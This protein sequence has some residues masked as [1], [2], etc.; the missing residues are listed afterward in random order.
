MAKD[1][2]KDK[3][4]GKTA[5]ND[6]DEIIPNQPDAGNVSDDGPQT[7]AHMLR[8]LSMFLYL[9]F[10][11]CVLP[12][13]YSPDPMAQVMGGNKSMMLLV[14]TSIA[15]IF[16]LI[17]AYAKR[18]HAEGT[19]YHSHFH[20]MIRTFWIGGAVYMPVMT[21]VFVIVAYAQLPVNEI[22]AQIYDPTLDTSDPEAMRALSK[23]LTTTYGPTINRISMIC[24]AP[25]AG[26]W[27]LRQLRGL[28]LAVRKQEVTR[29]K[30]WLL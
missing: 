19:I 7:R 13:F 8:S 10:A 20:W 30:T 5:K 21:V 15:T 9:V 11:S 26:W 22:V 6:P 4:T 28:V 24:M 16:A 27:I 29:V 1:K 2:N 14:F 18:S 25:F 23:R 17:I 3:D 12:L